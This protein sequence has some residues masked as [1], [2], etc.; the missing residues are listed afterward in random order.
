[1]LLGFRINSSKTVLLIPLHQSTGFFLGSQSDR[2]K[3]QIPATPNQTPYRPSAPQLAPAPTRNTCT[4]SRPSSANCAAFVG[5]VPRISNRWIRL[6]N[7]TGSARDDGAD[8]RG[9]PIRAHLFSTTGRKRSRSLV[10]RQSSIGRAWFAGCPAI[11]D[12]LF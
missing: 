2:Q 8:V 1:M 4:N 12:C 6:W 3:P 11:F 9:S 10:F 7:E 5:D